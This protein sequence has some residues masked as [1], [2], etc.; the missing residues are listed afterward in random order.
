MQGNITNK[1][2]KNF[3]YYVTL[4]IRK[5]EHNKA[6]FKL[7]KKHMYADVNITNNKVNQ[8]K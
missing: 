6:K 5:C 2:V 8:T 3:T 7:E 1:E 4:V